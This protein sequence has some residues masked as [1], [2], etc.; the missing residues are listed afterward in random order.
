MF[1]RNA[2]KTGSWDVFKKK[3]LLL[4]SNIYVLMNIVKEVYNASKNISKYF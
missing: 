3:I 4:F 1:L 2:N